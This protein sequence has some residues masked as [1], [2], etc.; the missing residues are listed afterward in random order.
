MELGEGEAGGAFEDGDADAEGGRVAAVPP[1]GVVGCADGFGRC[2]ADEIP[3]GGPLLTTGIG[4]VRGG[5]YAVLR[6]TER[7][8]NQDTATAT[9]VATAHTPTCRRPLRTTPSSPSRPRPGRAVRGPGPGSAGP[10]AGL[11]R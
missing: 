3:G 11:A 8:P 2:T 7:T 4:T 6:S 1:V 9:A 10:V 5:P